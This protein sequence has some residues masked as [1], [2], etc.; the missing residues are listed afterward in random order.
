MKRAYLICLLQS[1][2]AT[3]LFSQSNPVPLANLRPM[4]RSAPCGG[5]GPTLRRIIVLLTAGLFALPL[6]GQTNDAWL[7][8]TG[9]WSDG[10]KWSAGVPTAS[11]NVFIDNGSGT[12][13]A[14][15]VDV[16]ASCNNLTIDSDDSLTIPSGITLTV[17][18]TTIGNEGHI[19]ITDNRPQF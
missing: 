13:S 10:S 6:L 3:L 11:S 2:T 7:G 9:N 15:T 14:V 16:A 5:I 1:L 12:A 18:G 19:N 17:N 8:G 4:P